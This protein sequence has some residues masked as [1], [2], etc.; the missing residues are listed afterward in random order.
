[1]AGVP[2]RIGCGEGLRFCPVSP[3]SCSAA[4][5]RFGRGSSSHPLGVLTPVV[6]SLPFY[7]GPNESTLDFP[8]IKQFRAKRPLYGR[9]GKLR[10]GDAWQLVRGRDCESDAAAPGP[11]GHGP[12]P[13]HRAP[14]CRPSPGCAVGVSVSQPFQVIH[15]YQRWQR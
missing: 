12:P 10:Q 5:S 7:R 4:R 2:R 1:M 9:G 13:A 8:Q 15:L 6:P 11:L 3:P 14:P